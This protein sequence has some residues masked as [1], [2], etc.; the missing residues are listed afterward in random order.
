MGVRLPVTEAEASPRRAAPSWTAA[1]PAVDRSA[2]PAFLTS[3]VSSTASP[4]RPGAGQAHAV[5][6]P[7]PARSNPAA[8]PP[9]A[10][11]GLAG[12]AIVLILL[13]STGEF[14]PGMLGV[15]LFLV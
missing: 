6:P 2:V 11:S 4:A 9:P 10:V 3:A 7:D 15:E 14:R 8:G 13:H 1:R 5:Q 12:V